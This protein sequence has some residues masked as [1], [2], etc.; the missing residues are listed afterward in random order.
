M[1]KM[2]IRVSG[3]ELRMGKVRSGTCVLFMPARL[4]PG[5][6]FLWARVDLVWK[7][8]WKWAGLDVLGFAL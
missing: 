2:G 3:R 4:G 6:L 7:G 1:Y 8:R 5:F